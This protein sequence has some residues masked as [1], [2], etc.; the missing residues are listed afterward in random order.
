MSASRSAATVP[1][2]ASSGSASGATDALFALLGGIAGALLFTLVYRLIEA[3]LIKP[4]NY[5]KITL[6]D[7]LHVP[8]LVVAFVL[9]ACS[10]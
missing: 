6:A 3:T 4:L 1:A 9:A 7:V 8:P 2:P 10:S 5:G